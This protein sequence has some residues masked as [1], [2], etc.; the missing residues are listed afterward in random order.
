MDNQKRIKLEGK[1]KEKAAI[2]W[3][4]LQDLLG[5]IFTDAFVHGYKHG[6]EAREQEEKEESD[7]VTK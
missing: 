7:A 5:H 6:Y 3:L 2:H 1:A 4:W